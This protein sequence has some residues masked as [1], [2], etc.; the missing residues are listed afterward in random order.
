MLI[1]AACILGSSE[2]AFN[3]RVCGAFVR[4]AAIE[5]E[6]ML[7]GRMGGQRLMTWSRRNHIRGTSVIARS[8]HQFAGI[9]FGNRFG[10]RSPV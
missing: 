10:N 4:A 8:R 5:S 2:Y 3:L 6:G 7:G 9:G 1:I